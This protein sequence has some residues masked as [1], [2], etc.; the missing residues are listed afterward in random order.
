MHVYTRIDGDTENRKH[1][2]SPTN[3]GNENALIIMKKHN[4]EHSSSEDT[5]SMSLAALFLSLTLKLRF[6]L[7]VVR[8]K[9]PKYVALGVFHQ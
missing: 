5:V 6:D 3:K 7:P 2:E 1:L 9:A 8:S 4:L